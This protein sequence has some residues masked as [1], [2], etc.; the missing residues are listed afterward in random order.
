MT[1]DFT[2]S[3]SEFTSS[4]GTIHVFPYMNSLDS[5]NK[6][7]VFTVKSRVFHMMTHT[8]ETVPI[9]THYDSCETRS[10]LMKTGT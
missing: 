2:C 8:S 9:L 1:C 7:D 5:L 6:F 3:V 4:T 10:K